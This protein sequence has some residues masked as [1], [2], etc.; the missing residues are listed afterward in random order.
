MPG[1]ELKKDD[2]VVIF[3]TDHEY[4]AGM[5][6]NNLESAGIE[7]NILSQKDHNFPTPGNMSV[8]KLLVRKADEDAALA[9]IQEINK[10]TAGSDTDDVQ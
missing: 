7:V 4:K 9:Y 8:V 6:K 3:K 1:S 2:W 5:L 10:N